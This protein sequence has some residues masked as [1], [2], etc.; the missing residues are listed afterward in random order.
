MYIYSIQYLDLHLY[1]FQGKGY[2]SVLKVHR[3]YI[4]FLC[5][6][7]QMDMKCRNVVIVGLHSQ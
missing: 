7:G 1:L 4:G 5:C 3:P 6:S 2:S